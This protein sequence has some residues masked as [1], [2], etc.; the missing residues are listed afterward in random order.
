MAITEDVAHRIAEAIEAF[1]SRITLVAFHHRGPLVGGHGARARV[2]K[3]IDQHIGSREKEEIVVGIFEQ[4]FAL[5]A[6]GP[7]NRLNTLDAEGFDDGAGHQEL[8]NQKLRPG[9]YWVLRSNS[10]RPPGWKLEPGRS[11]STSTCSSAS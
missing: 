10:L 9:S 8:L 5:G 1:A 2:G 6:G 7:A 4:H 3:Q 11:H